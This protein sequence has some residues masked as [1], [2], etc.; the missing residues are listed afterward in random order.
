MGKFAN[1]TD[2]MVGLMNGSAN[3]AVGEI[4]RMGWEEVTK[5]KESRM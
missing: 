3:H 2:L 5:K 1:Q 4:R